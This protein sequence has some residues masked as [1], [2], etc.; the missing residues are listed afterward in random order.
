MLHEFGRVQAARY[1][2][3]GTEVEVD[4]DLPES[5]KRRLGFDR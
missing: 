4:V 2:E 1:S 3:D 5:V